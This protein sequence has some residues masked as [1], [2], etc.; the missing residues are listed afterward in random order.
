ME[1]K[2]VD[3]LFTFL[4]TGY[5]EKEILEK[6]EVEWKEIHKP[7]IEEGK[8]STFFKFEDETGIRAYWDSNKTMYWLPEGKRSINY[9]AGRLNVMY[10]EKEP[11]PEYIGH[12]LYY[13]KDESFISEEF[14]KGKTSKLFSKLLVEFDQHCNFQCIRIIVGGSEETFIFTENEGCIGGDFYAEHQ[15]LYEEKR[16]LFVL[17]TN[18]SLG[19]QYPNNNL[20]P[21]PSSIKKYKNLFKEHFPT[22]WSS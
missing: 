16:D 4:S 13:Y 15:H 6:M 10:V 2:M 18:T 19:T 21:D 22:Y 1:N 14:F 3:N 9:E 7:Y 17:H 20:W 12:Y 11:K 5:L 8:D